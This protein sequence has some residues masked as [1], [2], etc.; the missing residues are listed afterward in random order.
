[1]TRHEAG[2]TLVEVLVVLFAGSLLLVSLSWVLQGSARDFRGA[3]VKDVFGGSEQQLQALSSLVEQALPSP[4]GADGVNTAEPTYLVPA[5]EALGVVGPV[6]LALVV[7]PS[8]G[9]QAL[10]ARFS[11]TKETSAQFVPL[12]APLLDGVFN[13]SMQLDEVPDPRLPAPLRVRFARDGEEQNL[14]FRPRVTADRA[15]QFDPI[16]LACRQ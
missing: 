16:S 9:G 8:K 6:R 13:L 5:P 3:V 1:M 14:V 10:I 2:F 12:E 4:A 15:C 11:P 7:Q